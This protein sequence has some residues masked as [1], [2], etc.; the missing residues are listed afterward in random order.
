MV[1]MRI[2]T[3]KNYFKYEKE[4]LRVFM[5]TGTFKN[6]CYYEGGE[7]Y[8]RVFMTTD[9]FKNYFQYGKV[10]CGCFWDK[11][12]CVGFVCVL[13]ESCKNA[14]SIQ[15]KKCQYKNHE[16]IYSRNTILWY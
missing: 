9:T 13:F 15:V 1:F 8:L 11:V 12:K 6:Y 10:L 7:R 16:N 4:Y 5:S 2:D 3:F 14:K